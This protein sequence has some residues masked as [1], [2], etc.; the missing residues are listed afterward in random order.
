ML[1][2]STRYIFRPSLPLARCFPASFSPPPSLTSSH[3]SRSVKWLKARKRGEH[4][5]RLVDREGPFHQ[6]IGKSCGVGPQAMPGVYHFQRHRQLR[7][8]NRLIQKRRDSGDAL[9]FLA[10]QRM[11]L[12]KTIGAWN[13]N[14]VTRR[15]VTPRHGSA[16]PSRVEFGG[17]TLMEMCTY[18]Q[19]C[20]LQ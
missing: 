13:K 6:S 14:T 11:F 4:A 19:P 17:K 3:R 2:Y 5:Y 18:Y 9:K 1:T 7:K 20:A 15:M 10:E 8:K 12:H 16:R